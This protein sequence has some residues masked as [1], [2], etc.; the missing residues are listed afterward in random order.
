MV[1]RHKL[2][3]KIALTNQDNIRLSSITCSD[4]RMDIL[5]NQTLLDTPVNKYEIS[6]PVCNFPKIDKTPEPYFIAKNR[7]FS[8][9]EIMIADLGNLFISDRLKQVFEILFPNQCYY[10]KTFMQDT[11]ISTKWWLAIPT[12]L[13]ITGEVNSKVKRCKIC[14]E[15]FYAHPGTQYKFWNEDIETEFD[16]IKSKN[17][18]S[19]DD[20]D[21]KRS[22]V[23]RDILISVR[24]ISLFKIIGAKGIYQYAFSKFKKL[25]K[26]EK[27]WVESSI[28]KIGNL[29][30]T[31]S[32]EITKVSLDKFI[33]HFSIAKI[34]GSTKNDFEKKF[35]TQINEIIEII[36]NIK[37][38]TKIDVGFDSSFVVEQFENWQSTKS[39]PKLIAFAFDEFGNE[40]LFD[41]K[42]KSCPVYYFDHETMIYDLVNS[43]IVN[44]YAVVGTRS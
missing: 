7:N 35:K 11:T 26:E 36:C 34:A 27:K 42:D 38:G 29:K 25:T 44:I 22:W 5:D 8:G 23:N 14:N 30:T 15:P 31:T 41:P 12:N 24:L 4:K 28:L 33:K 18:H 13:V 1:K 32:F 17:W 39:K 2:P 10:Q 16:I 6:C 21:W 40:L 20:K 37:S 19:T 3:Y 9:I 43:S